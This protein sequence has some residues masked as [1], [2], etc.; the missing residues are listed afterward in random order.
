MKVRPATVADVP[1]IHALIKH[2]AEAQ[3]MI[4]R[5]FDELYGQVRSF[6]VAESEGRIVGCASTY[7]FWADLA[8]MKCVAVAPDAAR[9][10]VGKAL[11]AR[12]H[13]QLRSLGVKRVFALTGAVGFFEKLGYRRVDKDSLPRFIWGECTRCPSFP[14][15]NEE[16]LVLDLIPEAC[17]P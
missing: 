11:V 8:E 12:C 15:C 2:H 16:A 9:R 4:L 10:G 3:R 14:V 1:A 7:V 13:D 6:F 5:A 17:G